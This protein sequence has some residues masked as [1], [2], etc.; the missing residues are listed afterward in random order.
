ML[1]IHI[2]DYYFLTFFVLKKTKLI[3]PCRL[4]RNTYILD[5]RK[6]RFLSRSSL[7]LY[8]DCIPYSSLKSTILNRLRII[9]TPLTV[10]I[11]L[12]VLSLVLPNSYGIVTQTGRDIS[13]ISLSM[14]KISPGSVRAEGKILLIKSSNT[15]YFIL[16]TLPSFQI[17]VSTT[18]MVVLLTMTVLDFGHK[19]LFH[20]LCLFKLSSFHIRD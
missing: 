13:L 3:L 10:V 6:I 2:S 20:C 9:H 7:W 1:I 18:I 15:T 12:F 16:R 4:T 11:S 19:S 8:Y 14:I 5:Y 17:K